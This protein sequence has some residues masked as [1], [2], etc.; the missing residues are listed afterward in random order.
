MG[1]RRSRSVRKAVRDWEVRALRAAGALNRLPS[2]LTAVVEQRMVRRGF[3]TL[4][5]SARE[6]PGTPSA[7]RLNR[8]LKTFG[9][10][11]YLEIGVATGETIEAVGAKRVVGVDPAH[12][13]NSTR[14]PGHIR[15]VAQPSDDFFDAVLSDPAATSKRFDLIFVDGLHTFDQSYRDLRNA[16]G[17]LHDHGIVVVDDTIPSSR[18]AALADKRLAKQ[19][20]REHGIA[21]TDWMGDVYKTVVAVARF[22]PSLEMVTVEDALHRGQTFIWRRRGPTGAPLP[23]E[24]V[25]AAELATVDALEFDDVFTPGVPELFNRGSLEDA[26]AAR[27]RQL[28]GPPA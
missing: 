19:L 4:A 27:R 6:A 11:R 28:P 12:Q 17:A 24:V 21:S 2:P 14:L 1:T 5:P 20:R 10:E 13:V 7:D 22:H 8:I 25:T 16:F 9:G 26:I 15:L 23:L 18:F 3:R